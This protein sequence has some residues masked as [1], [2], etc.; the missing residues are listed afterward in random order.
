MAT[1]KGY[2]ALKHSVMCVS[3]QHLAN[4][5]R[6]TKDMQKVV[7]Y[8]DLAVQHRSKALNLLRVASVDQ[9]T[10]DEAIAPAVLL[11]LVLSAVS[12]TCL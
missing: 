7:A 11:M 3:A 8:S 6:K 1:E 9:S 10:K 2:S 5:A 4:W 12:S